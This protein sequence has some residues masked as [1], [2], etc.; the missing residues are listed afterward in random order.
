[1]FTTFDNLIQCSKIF[2]RSLHVIDNVQ[3][4][5]KVAN[6]IDNSFLLTSFAF[7]SSFS[8]FYL[9]NGQSFLEASK[10]F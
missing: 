2:S 8:N 7:A 1:M 6:A 3:K 4:D 5:E 9:F 10:V